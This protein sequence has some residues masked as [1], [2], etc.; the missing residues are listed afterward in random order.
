MTTKP[1][2]PIQM[3]LVTTPATQHPDAQ[4]EPQRGLDDPALVVHARIARADGVGEPR[5]IGVE[6]LLNLLELALLVL[7]ERHGASHETCARGAAR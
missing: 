6:R 3:Y 4:Q 7:R 1:A 5:I 2:T